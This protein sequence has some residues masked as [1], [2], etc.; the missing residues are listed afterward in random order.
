M[1]FASFGFDMTSARDAASTA[2]T[3]PARYYTDPAIFERELDVF[4]RRMWIG[5][6]RLEEIPP[7][8]A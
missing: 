6:A 7:R 5:V 2:F 8:G 1:T 3:L 4:Y